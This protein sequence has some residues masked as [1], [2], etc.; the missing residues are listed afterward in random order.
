MKTHKVDYY[1]RHEETYWLMRHLRDYGLFRDEHQD[2][3]DEM[4]RL[5]A[6]RGKTKGRKP[7]QENKE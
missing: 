6:L 5:R 2:F 3:N 1:P 7:K 4:K